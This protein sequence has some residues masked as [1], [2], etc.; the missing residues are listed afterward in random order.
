MKDS[1]SCLADYFTWPQVALTHHVRSRSI[2]TPGGG[3]CQD[4]GLRAL[5]CQTHFPFLI[6]YNFLFHSQIHLGPAL[7]FDQ[8]GGRLERWDARAGTEADEK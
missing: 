3:S 5:G 4:E 8:G 1:P 6:S 7:L 2:E